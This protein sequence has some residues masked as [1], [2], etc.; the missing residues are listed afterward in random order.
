MRGSSHTCDNDV[1]VS[2]TF[3]GCATKTAGLSSKPLASLFPSHVTLGKSLNHCRLFFSLINQGRGVAR[4]QKRNQCES[5][6]YIMHSIYKDPNRTF[7]FYPKGKNDL[8]IQANHTTL[9]SHKAAAHVPTWVCGPDQS[10]LPSAGKK[11]KIN[12][13]ASLNC[14][15]PEWR[16]H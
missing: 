16:K 10:M 4:T 13:Q 1:P 8:Q 15:R 11:E 2:V 12:S 3:P 9:R 6:W 14:R 7:V 5:V